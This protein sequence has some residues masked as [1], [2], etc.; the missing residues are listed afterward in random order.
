MS[1]ME[2]SK[3]SS[4]SSVC[5]GRN[6]HQGGFGIPWT[7]QIAIY[8]SNW[9]NFAFAFLHVLNTCNLLGS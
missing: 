6:S 2:S 1:L 8:I 4:R 3:A 9:G 7:L 5:G